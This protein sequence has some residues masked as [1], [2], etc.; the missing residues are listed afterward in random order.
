[1]ARKGQSFDKLT[2]LDSLGD[3]EYEWKKEHVTDYL[4]ALNK[5]PA[6]VAQYFESLYVSME[7]VVDTSGLSDSQ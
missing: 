2:A 6:V 4:I 5:D 7:Q 3:I 1:M